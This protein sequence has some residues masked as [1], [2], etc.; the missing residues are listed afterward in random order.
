M[1]YLMYNGLTQAIYDEYGTGKEFNDLFLCSGFHPLSGN[2]T[3][4]EDIRI[5]DYEELI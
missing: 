4:D 1:R 2:E 5:H 3:A